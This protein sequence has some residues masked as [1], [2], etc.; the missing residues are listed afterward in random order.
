MDDKQV[1]SL[2]VLLFEEGGNH[3]LPDEKSPDANIR[4]SRPPTR[5]LSEAVYWER[6]SRAFSAGLQGF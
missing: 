1:R 3:V 5:A 6:Q 4:S 2:R